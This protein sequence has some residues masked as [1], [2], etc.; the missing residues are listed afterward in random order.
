MAVVTCMALVENLCSLLISTDGAI[1]S[2][3]LVTEVTNSRC[4]ERENSTMLIVSPEYG[5]FTD[6][7]CCA[8]GI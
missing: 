6:Y 1:I 5:I 8:S 7:V 3:I 4:L 2:I